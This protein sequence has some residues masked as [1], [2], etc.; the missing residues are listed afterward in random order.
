MPLRTFLA[1]D[2]DEQIIAGLLKAAAQL[3]DDADKIAWVGRANMHVTLKFL[4]DVP[5]NQIGEVCSIIS[6]VAAE[7]EPFAFEV[8]GLS[9]TPPRGPVRMIWANIHD[10]SGLMNVLHDELDAAL[11]GMG[12]K[13]EQ[14]GFHPHITLARVKHVRS[15]AAFRSA[16][17]NFADL[18]LGLQHAEEVVVYSSAHIAG[19][20]VY[21]PLSFARIGS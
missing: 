19:E 18:S 7:I 1:L 9:C 3:Q 21:S 10:D 13:E 11:S 2:L 6:A 14:R 8:R 5:E 15:I 16:V 12:L 17:R 4:G 20:R